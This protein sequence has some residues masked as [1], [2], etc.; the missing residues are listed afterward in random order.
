MVSSSPMLLGQYR[1]LDS[2]LHRLDVRAKLVPVLLVMVLGLLSES[3]IF[4][5][6]SLAA[7]LGGLAFSGVSAAA[8]G[9]SFRPILILVV[10][11][12]A[13][14]IIFTGQGGE[15][16]VEFL[17]FSVT[18]LN[19]SRAAFFSTR[20]LLF[21]SV[22]FIVTLTSSPS[23]LA[24]A[25][26]RLLRPLER[27]GIPADDLG[28]VLFIAIRFIPVLTQEFQTIRNAQVIRG[29]DFSGSLVNRVRRTAT[30]IIPVLVAAIARAD[31]LALAMEARGYRSGRRRTFYTR[32]RFDLYAWIFVLGSSLLLGLAFYS[33]GR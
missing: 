26:A 7:L 6:I 8:I 30:V 11:T 14:H 24:E 21:V 2:F 23:E 33:T 4:Y 13:Y 27:I 31:E 32:A 22:V 15:P 12:F 28:L 18:D 1:P 10:I 17:G 19:L 9:R 16:L 25:I 20:L 3:L 29:V 5:V